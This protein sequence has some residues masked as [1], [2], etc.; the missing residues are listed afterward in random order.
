MFCPKCGEK[1]LDGAEFC[2]K[3]G[4]K[5]MKDASAQSAASNPE[6]SVQ[7]IS[8]APTAVPKKKKSKKIFIILAIVF[9]FIVI[10]IAVN[11]GDIEERGEQVERDEEYINS[12]QDSTNVK[13]SETYTNKEEGISFQYPS[14]WVPVNADRY[15]EW[16]NDSQIPL[17]VLANENEDIPENNT[18]VLVSKFEASQEDVEYLFGDDEEFA[19]SF[20]NDAG[21]TSGDDLEINET[22]VVELDKVPARMLM[23]ASGDTG[24]QVYFYSAN[25]NIYRVEFCWAG[26]NPGNNQRFFD[27]IIDSYKITAVDTGE[28]DS[29]NAWQSAAD[30][31]L[32]N[33]IPVDTIM[34]MKAEDVIAAFGE[35]DEYSDE[36]FVQI[37]S[38]DGERLVAI[39]NFDS[40]G[41]VSYFTG[42]P[43][44]F[45][46]NGQDLNHDY[47]KLVKIFGREPDYE[48]TFDLL[49][50]RWFF[51]GYSILLGLDEDGLPGKTEIWK[52]NAMDYE[53]GQAELDPELMGRW[54]AYDGNALTLNDNGTVSEVFSFWNSLN[55]KPDSVAWEASNG[56]LILTA[57][58]NTE[59][60]Y[61]LGEGKRRINGEDVVTDELNLDRSR[62]PEASEYGYYYR[63]KTGSTDLTGTWIHN[64]SKGLGG[65]IEFYADGTGMIGDNPLTWYA[66]ESNLYYT[67]EQKAAFDYTVSGD[68]LT[69]FFSDGSR[70]YTK[71]GN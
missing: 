31:L 19:E 16:F 4:A 34:E 28:I 29:A 50:V 65:N 11:S 2:Q 67:A 13:L 62:I 55:R 37:L 57:I 14:A 12:Q 10:L 45:E 41:Y 22:L 71:I 53:G 40:A 18:Y 36:N 48:E 25:S 17:V 7:S 69:I 66:D 1:V 39:A 30:Q 64:D 68:V 32:Y 52:D 54:R 70:M 3:C 9:A 24:F 63:E 44:K 58:Y 23:A 42:D 21:T 33:G 8:K 27:A 15:G 20:K 56:H 61:A 46:L 49:E 26:E 35:A 59:Y 38:E 5:L 60:K 43:E 51:D 47:D 6:S